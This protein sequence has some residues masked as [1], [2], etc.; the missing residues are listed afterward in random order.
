M[1]KYACGCKRVSLQTHTKINILFY[2]VA[3]LQFAL[4]FF[5]ALTQMKLNFLF[6]VW[7]NLSYDE[8]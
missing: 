3:G 1:R 7:E 4:G 2:D 6:Y 5:H 8:F